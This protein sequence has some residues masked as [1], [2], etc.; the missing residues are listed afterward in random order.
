LNGKA[1]DKPFIVTGEQLM[2]ILPLGHIRAN[3]LAAAFNKALPRYGMDNKY[4]FP[5]YLAQVAHESGNF[6]AKVEDLRY[7]ADTLV[8]VFKN[9]FPT[10]GSTVGYVREPVK[11]AN[12]V[13][14]NRMGNGDEASGDGW[15]NRGGGYIQLTGYV[16][17]SMYLAYIQQFEPDMTMERLQELVR[18]TEY[19]A[20]DSSLWYF[21][22]YA[23][24]K[25]EAHKDQFLKITKGVNGGYN[26]VDHRKDIFT[27]GL[28]V[29]A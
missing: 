4:V 28:K 2:K 3:E 27:A 16:V 12:K 8:R 29:Y 21:A 23:S 10:I 26:G 18:T 5:D 20:I 17:W 14:A 9:Y 1:K 19:Y 25:D 22:V 15:K 11:I 7:K 24:L 6:G 13:Y